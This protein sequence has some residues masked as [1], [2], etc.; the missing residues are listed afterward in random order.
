MSVRSDFYSILFWGGGSQIEHITANTVITIIF[1]NSFLCTGISSRF[2]VVFS[3]D[4]GVFCGMAW[5]TAEYCGIFAHEILRNSTKVLLKKFWLPRS[6]KNPLPWTPYS[7]P[8]KVY[9][10]T[11]V[12]LLWVSTLKIS[13]GHPPSA[14]THLPTPIFSRPHFLQNT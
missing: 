12:R 10:C 13:S 14:R 8:S 5:N 11:V 3:R 7:Q 1:L 4:S 9:C 2:I 6:Y